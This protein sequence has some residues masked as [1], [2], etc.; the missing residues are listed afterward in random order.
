MKSILITYISILIAVV[1]ADLCNLDV[2]M[3]EE[4]APVIY[5]LEFQARALAPQQAETEAVRFYVGTQSLKFDNQVH[6]LELD[7]ESN[8]IKTEIFL[9][10]EG[11]IWHIS[12]SPTDK[13]IIS[14][15]YNHISATNKTCSKHTAVWKTTDEASSSSEICSLNLLTKLNTAPLG[16]DIKCTYFHPTE[17]NKL[18]TVVDGNFAIWDLNTAGKTCDAATKGAIE[19]KGQPKF[20]T[21]KWNPHQGKSQLATANEMFIRGWDTRT[22]QE[23]WVIESAHNQ[24]V[25]D[26][27]FN[28]NRQYFLASCGDDG[29]SKFWDIR[30]TSSPVVTRA[31]H[32]HWVWCIRFNHFHDQLV[33]TSSTD[34]RVILLSAASISSEPYG[35]IVEEESPS[36]EKSAPLKDGVLAIYEEHE[37]SVYAV[38]WSSGDPWTFASLS[39]DG[40]L[41]INQVP[42]SEKYRL[43]L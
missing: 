3:L 25:R 36:E 30:K 7:E 39:Y 19:G 13:N 1:N 21:A 4:D 18:L 34:S 16:E 37:D 27:D 11:E 10:T 41:I 35:H 26:I 8:M 24:L 43:L 42:K 40:R 32:S 28:P 6:R 33:L 22:S 9:H 2:K 17:E 14:T 29:N 31:D 38:E 20:S 23:A 5:G 12:S 15:V